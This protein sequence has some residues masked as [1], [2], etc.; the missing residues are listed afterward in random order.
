MVLLA[1]VIV[2]VVAT[3]GINFTILVPPLAQGILHV[4]AEGYGFLMA[5]SG[6]GSLLAALAIAFGGTRPSRMLIG[7]LVLG[8][9]EIL[10]GIVGSYPIDLVLM[11]VAG[12]GAITMM[13]T[14][15]TTIQMVVPDE[16]RGRV[17]SVYT[18]VFAGTSPIGGLVLG[19]L[20]ANAGAATAIAWGGVVSVGAAVLGLI[21]YRRLRRAPTPS[22]QTS[23]TGSMAPA[24]LPGSKSVI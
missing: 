20:A 14:A 5:A 23:V 9:A 7:G 15:N 17:M 13:A 21:W 12:S 19:A 1:V 6:V 8:V 18:T 11:F 16:L 10:I 22:G 3:F 24:S 4:G 2:G